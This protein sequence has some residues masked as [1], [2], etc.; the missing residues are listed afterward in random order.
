MQSLID[1]LY[2]VSVPEQRAALEEEFAGLYSTPAEIA[3]DKRV[4][5]S[6]GAHVRE[7]TGPKR[8]FEPCL[9]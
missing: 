3:A 6:I 5:A 8:R 7:M 4:H 9:S 1:T 2:T